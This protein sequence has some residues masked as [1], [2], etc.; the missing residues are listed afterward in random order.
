MLLNSLNRQK[1]HMH[2]PDMLKG[3]NPST[4]Y[5]INTEADIRILQPLSC[6]KGIETNHWQT[7]ILECIKFGP[8][9]KYSITDSSFPTFLSLQVPGAVFN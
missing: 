3:Y 4:T 9:H 2:A 6:A 5:N 8:L 1:E 7:I